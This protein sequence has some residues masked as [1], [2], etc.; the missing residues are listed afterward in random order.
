MSRAWLV[1]VFLD[2][3]TFII[4]L[5]ALCNDIEISILQA[6][7]NYAIKILDRPANTEHS[8]CA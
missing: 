8:T 5:C 2:Y 6:H 7:P 3:F 4:I 1:H